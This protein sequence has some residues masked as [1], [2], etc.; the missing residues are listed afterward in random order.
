MNSIKRD[1]KEAFCHVCIANTRPS[2]SAPESNHLLLIRRKDDDFIRLSTSVFSM[3]K[4]EETM[5]EPELSIKRTHSIKHR[6]TK[7]Y[8]YISYIYLYVYIHIPEF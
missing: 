4:A 2:Q 6:S 8:I 7:R 5:W 3:D 1:Y